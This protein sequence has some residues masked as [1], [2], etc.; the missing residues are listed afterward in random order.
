MLHIIPQ[1]LNGI[2]P[3]V[4]GTLDNGLD[5]VLEITLTD[6]FGSE[7]MTLPLKDYTERWE[8]GYHYH[9]TITVTADPIDFTAPD[10]EITTRVVTM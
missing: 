8:I 4:N 2:F 9:Y 7:V 1:Y 6:G 3:S 5:V 10:F